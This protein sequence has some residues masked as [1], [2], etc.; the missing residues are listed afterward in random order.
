MLSVGACSGR[1]PDGRTT[2]SVESGT[3]AHVADGLTSIAAVHAPAAWPDTH[4]QSHTDTAVYM[5]LVSLR[6][7]A[8]TD[9]AAAAAA[10]GL[11]VLTGP[12]KLSLYAVSTMR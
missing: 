3:A 6:P 8:H 10:V 4:T 9:A 11:S 7:A 2:R 12:L 5:R 1:T